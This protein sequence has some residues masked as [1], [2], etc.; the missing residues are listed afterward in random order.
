MEDFRYLFLTTIPSLRLGLN[1][2]RNINREGSVKLGSLFL[3]HALL[4]SFLTSII[5]ISMASEDTDSFLQ[6]MEDKFHDHNSESESFSSSDDDH[7]KA[8]KSNVYRL[9]GREQPVHKVLGGGKRNLHSFFF[10][11]FL[12]IIFL[13]THFTHGTGFVFD[14]MRWKTLITS[15][16]YDLKLALEGCITMSFSY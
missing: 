14:R 9:F 2:P 12:V 4:L 8:S 10:F 15:V 6:K 13:V 5:R 16:V 1:N 11:V 7:A 3:S